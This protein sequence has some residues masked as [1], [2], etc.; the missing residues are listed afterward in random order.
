[1]KLLKLIAL[2]VAALPIAV[3]TGALSFA[4]AE[5]ST[6]PQV[7]ALP[8][9]IQ[10]ARVLMHKEPLAWPEKVSADREAKV[11]VHYVIEP[12]GSVDHIRAQTGAE[13]A[14]AAAARQAVGHFVYAP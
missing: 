13:P 2:P 12:D 9:A 5:G 6:T 4:R 8:P 3:L 11:I 7:A 14:F 1:M 10:A